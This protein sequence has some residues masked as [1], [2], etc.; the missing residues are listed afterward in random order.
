LPGGQVSLYRSVMAKIVVKKL[1]RPQ[2]PAPTGSKAGGRARCVD[3]GL[4][5]FSANTSSLKFEQDFTQVF[6]RSVAKA[7]RENKKLTGQLDRAPAKS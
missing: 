3:H 4:L 6:A 2:R 1:G 5:E 7:R